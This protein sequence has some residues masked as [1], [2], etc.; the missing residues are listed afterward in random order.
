MLVPF[1]CQRREFGKCT[2]YRFQSLLFHTQSAGERSRISRVAAP[3]SVEMSANER[4]PNRVTQAHCPYVINP[5]KVSYICI[6]VAP[7]AHVGFI[8]CGFPAEPHR[9]VGGAGSVRQRASIH[10]LRPGSVTYRSGEVFCF[11]RIVSRCAA[12]RSP[13]YEETFL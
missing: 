6:F 13:I 9:R 10:V 3:D 12:F 2:Q 11:V 8:N 5:E 1:R 7:L 4:L